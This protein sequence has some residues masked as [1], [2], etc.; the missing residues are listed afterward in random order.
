MTVLRNLLV[1]ALVAVL[2]TACGVRGAPEPPAG[3]EDVP[4]DPPFVLDPLVE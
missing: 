3:A 1:A 2:V 4:R